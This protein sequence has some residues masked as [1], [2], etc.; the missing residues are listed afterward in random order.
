MQINYKKQTRL[1]IDATSGCISHMKVVAAEMSEENHALRAEVLETIYKAEFNYSSSS[2]ENDG[3]RFRMM[4]PQQPAA[5][6]YSC[7]YTKSPYLLRYGVVEHLLEGQIK[8]VEGVLYT[9]K[10]DET[11]KP[12]LVKQYYGYLCYWS[13][14]FEQVANIYTGLLF[15]GHL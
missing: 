2:A 8:D 11:R 15:M 7:L 5:E 6:R 1:K 4:F 9:F 12:Q 13:P 10:F 3:E 14:E